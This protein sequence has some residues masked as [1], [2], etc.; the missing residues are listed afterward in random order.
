MAL[1]MKQIHYDPPAQALPREHYPDLF[2]HRKD[3]FSGLSFNFIPRSTFTDTSEQRREVYEDLWAGGD[4]HFWLATYADM[5]FDPRANEEAYNFWCEKTRARIQDRNIKDILAPQKQPHAFG[6]KRISLENGYF[7][8]FNQEN[9]TLVDASRT[10]SP[11]QCI[12]EKGIQTKEGEHEV[13]IIVCATGYDAV[14]GG[15]MQIDIRG[16]GGVSLEDAWKDGT[17]TYLGMASQGFPN[18]FFTYGP[19]A[20]TAFCNGPTCAELQGDWILNVMNHAKQHRLTAVEVQ[21]QAQE[22]WKDLIWKLASASLLPAVDSWYMGTNVPGKL[23][24][25]LIYLGGVP[26]YH[27]TLEEVAE[28]G[29]EGFTL[30]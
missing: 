25:P 21:S 4:F 15:L 8:I 23:R 18:M 19:Q 29:Y 9:V 22:E 24:E 7:E 26:T 30:V 6:C 20:P 17:K 5:L 14:T 2:T 1:P 3:S 28:K 12:T 13:D 16:R 27:N 10:G 11:I